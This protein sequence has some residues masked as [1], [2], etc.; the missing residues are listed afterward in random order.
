MTLILGSAAPPVTADFPLPVNRPFTARAAAEAGISRERLRLGDD[1]RELYRIDLVVEEL[2][3]GCEYDGEAYHSAA[4]DRRH[5][6]DRR[7]TLDHR[8]GWLVTG[9][10][11]DNV[12]GPTRDVEG[13]LHAGIDEARKR[14]AHHRP[15]N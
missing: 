6:E 3:F 8:F 14:L 11:R 10:R 15:D 12:F 13:L 7:V 5:D 4:D 2:R 9:A 1:G